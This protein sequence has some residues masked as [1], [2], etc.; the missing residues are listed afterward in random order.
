MTSKTIETK[1]D[2]KSASPSAGPPAATAA[3]PKIQWTRDYL[4]GVDEQLHSDQSWAKAA[5][6]WDAKGI[7]A[8]SVVDAT[9]KALLDKKHKVTVVK[10]PAEA[11][12][13]LTSEALLPKGAS[14]AFGGSVTLEQLGFL[15]AVQQRSDLKNYR[16]LAIDAMMKGD[17]AGSTALRT[18]GHQKADFFYSSVSAITEDGVLVAADASGTRTAPMIA[19]AKN[20]VIVA[21]AQKIV[22]TLTDALDRLTNYIVPIEGAHMR[23]VAKIPGT[24]LTNVVSIHTSGMQPGR[25]HIILIK[26]HSLGY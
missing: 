17:M 4:F 2:L 10:T 7:A 15:D 1:T 25:F 19:G 23:G 26:G 20:V 14:V 11:F 8:D 13:L 21:T 3:P 16:A 12:Q 18:E 24:S 5:A 6:K 22:P 9:A